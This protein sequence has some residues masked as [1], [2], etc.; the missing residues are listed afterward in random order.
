MTSVGLSLFNYQDD[1]RSNKNK[2]DNVF[3]LRLKISMKM[4]LVGPKHYN[5]IYL[6]KYKVVCDCI[7]YILYTVIPRLTSDPANEFFV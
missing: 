2:I 4:A 5:L 7:I 6:I 3:N 1:A